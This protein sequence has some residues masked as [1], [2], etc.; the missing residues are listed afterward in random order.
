MRCA[1]E[2]SV[3]ANLKILNRY[4]SGLINNYFKKYSLA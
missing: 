4:N 3:S 1:A 2:K